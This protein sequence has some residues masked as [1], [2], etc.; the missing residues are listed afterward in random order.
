AAAG[1]GGGGGGRLAPPAPAQQAADGAAQQAAEARAGQQAAA[2]LVQGGVVGAGPQAQGAGQV[3]QVLQEDGQA[4][5][6][7]LEEDLEHQAG[8]QLRLGELLGAA[9]VAGTGQ[10]A[11]AGRQGPAGDGHG[12]LAEVVHA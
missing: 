10:A 8:E 9:A 6:V 1:G 3:G 11:L 5:V 4:A 7:G 2:G 12:G